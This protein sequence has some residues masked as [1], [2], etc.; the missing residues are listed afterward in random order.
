MTRNYKLK[1]DFEYE[2]VPFVVR[3]YDTDMFIHAK[4]GEVRGVNMHG[5]PSGMKRGSRKWV[6]CQCR[7]CR[8]RPDYPYSID[9]EWP[10]SVDKHVQLADPMEVPKRGIVFY[11][12][13]EP[14]EEPREPQ[15]I[16]EAAIDELQR[17][18]EEAD[19]PETLEAT[20]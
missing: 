15:E 11:G 2:T 18:Y 1:D 14:D 6:M 13:G 8:V 19:E 3:V 20:P 12:R 9:K 5:A 4:T 7:V 10:E 16:A 17:R